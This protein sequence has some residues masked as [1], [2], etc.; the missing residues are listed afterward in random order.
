MDKESFSKFSTTSIST[1]NQIYPESSI[2][3]ESL[4]R[5]SADIED[6][7]IDTRLLK[8]QPA[9]SSSMEQTNDTHVLTTET[10][11]DSVANQQSNMLEDLP[12]SFSMVPGTSSD[13]DEHSKLYACNLCSFRTS[14]KNS[15]VNHQAVHSDDRPWICD[16]CDY[17]AKRKQDLKKHLHTMHGM[18]V[19]SL[20]LQPGVSPSALSHTPPILYPG[21]SPKE[22]KPFLNKPGEM[23]E[24]YLSSSSCR[25]EAMTK[26][27]HKQKLSPGQRSPGSS[28]DLNLPTST[29]SDFA[30]MLS[31]PQINRTPA[32]GPFINDKFPFNQF[33]GRNQKG[34]PPFTANLWSRA[35]QESKYQS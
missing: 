4:S 13:G 14:F 23:H 6:K 9:F 8:V 11:H 34:L 10:F 12:L 3:S 20:Q 1:T 32:V 18:W 35:S 15:L 5:K 21:T 30:H 7:A 22:S 28:S 29:F 25:S 19:D 31:L 33:F 24:P 27:I 2:H 26:S 16:I 17:R